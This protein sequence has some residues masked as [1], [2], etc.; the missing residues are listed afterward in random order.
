MS[1]RKYFMHIQD[2][3]KHVIIN[4]SKSWRN[5]DRVVQLVSDFQLPMENFGKYGKAKI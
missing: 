4:I 2:M 5:G 3:N 1:S